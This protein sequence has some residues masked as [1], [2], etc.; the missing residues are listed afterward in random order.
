MALPHIGLYILLF[1]YLMIGAWA[2][3]RLEYHAEI[4]YQ[5]EKLDKIEAVYK[6]ISNALREECSDFSQEQ[7]YG[8]LSR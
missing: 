4:T 6:Q 2:F 1:F 8:S 3:R 7:L 5:Q